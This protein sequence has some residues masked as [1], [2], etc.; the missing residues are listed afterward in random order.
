MQ[1]D[2]KRM[3]AYSSISHA[4][5]ML[6]A[7]LA[8]SGSSDNAIL[9]YTVAYSIAT[10]V[11]FMILYLVEKTTGSTAIAAFNGLGKSNPF[12]A[13]AMTI[14]LLSMAGIPPLSGFMA[15]Y[16]IFA[17]AISEGHLPLVLFAISMS[18]VGVYYYFKIIIAMFFSENITPS[19]MAQGDTE[20]STTIESDLLQNVLIIVGCAA[21]LLLGL[22]PSLVYNVL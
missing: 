9:F 3:L 21:M 22:L 20:G 1:T 12:L 15:K 11:G 13:V 2:A 4:G 19:V 7:L 16:Y 5:Y 6:L 17:N 14:S 8:M 10:I 18:L